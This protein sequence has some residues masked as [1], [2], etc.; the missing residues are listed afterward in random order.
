MIRNL[1]SLEGKSV[2]VIGAGSGIGQAVAI[3]TAQQGAYVCCLD[4]NTDNASE[5][6]AIIIKAGD[7]YKEIARNVLGEACKA[8]IAASQGNLFIR[9]DKHLFC[10]GEMN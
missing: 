9:S 6:A 4:L 2:A 8:S 3:G 5:T 7:K 10:I 1:F